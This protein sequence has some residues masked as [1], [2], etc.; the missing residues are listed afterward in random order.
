MQTGTLLEGLNTRGTKCLRHYL[1]Y[2]VR[3][4][5]I[6][7][8]QLKYLVRGGQNIMGDQISCDNTTNISSCCSVGIHK[9]QH[10]IVMYISFHLYLEGGGEWV[11]QV[12]AHCEVPAVFR[13]GELV[14]T[15]VSTCS[16]TWTVWYHNF[17]QPF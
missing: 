4:D 9:V 10:S 6:F 2:L 12:P 17:R 13:G 15:F 11:I 7:R 1:R 3:L 16:F 5:Q 14:F 8:L